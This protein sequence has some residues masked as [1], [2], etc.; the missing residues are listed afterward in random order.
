MANS[1]IARFI[2]EVAPPQYISVIRRRASKMLDTI[3]EEERDVSPSNSLAS[4]PT[5]P[6]SASTNAAS[7]SAAAPVATNSK[8]FPRRVQRSFSVFQN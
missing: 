4:A 7:A 8:Y 2:T 6:A 1:R 3:N 5:S